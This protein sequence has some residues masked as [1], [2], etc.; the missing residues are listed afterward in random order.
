M[1]QESFGN[2]FC[3][4][5]EAAGVEGAAHGLREARATRAPENG[6]SIVELR[7]MFGWSSDQMPALYTKAAD[8]VGMAG[9]GMS[10]LEHGRRK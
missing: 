2:W 1:T 7:A 3:E 6:A 9:T 4:V 8:R 10:K 5:C